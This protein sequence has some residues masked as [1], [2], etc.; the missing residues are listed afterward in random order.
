MQ[1][2]SP[3]PYRRVAVFS[4]RSKCGYI[5]Q[6]ICPTGANKSIR[7]CLRPFWVRTATTL[8]FLHSYFILPSSFRNP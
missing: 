2:V 6:L 3:Q 7:S 1:S 5:S 8:H 4:F